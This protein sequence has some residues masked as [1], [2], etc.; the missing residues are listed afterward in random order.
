MVGIDGCCVEMDMHHPG[1]MPIESVQ[2]IVENGQ[3]GQVG[4]YPKLE[5][6][7]VRVC[8][9]EKHMA[10]SPDFALDRWPE[11]SYLFHISSFSE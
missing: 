9:G 6:F 4:I 1:F 3:N 8:K 11:K 10:H 2:W 5:N 7:N